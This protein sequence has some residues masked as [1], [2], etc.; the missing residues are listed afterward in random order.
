VLVGPGDPLKLE[1]A[2]EDHTLVH[3]VAVDDA[4]DDG[5]LGGGLDGALGEG[6]GRARA[7]VDVEGRERD[8]GSSVHSG[9]T[10]SKTKDI[11]SALLKSL[12]NLSSVLLSEDKRLDLLV[13]GIDKLLLLSKRLLLHVLLDVSVEH[14]GALGGEKRAS[15]VGLLDESIINVKSHDRSRSNILQER[16]NLV[17]SERSMGR[18]VLASTNILRQRLLL[19]MLFQSVSLCLI[20]QGEMD[21]AVLNLLKRLAIN[22][23]TSDDRTTGA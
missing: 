4:V 17:Q 2:L 7:E 15:I 5:S 18:N 9:R 10:C 8:L 22:R 16:V 12:D 6:G 19:M 1:Q 3:L 21:G 23:S 13:K 20:R 14:T 11:A